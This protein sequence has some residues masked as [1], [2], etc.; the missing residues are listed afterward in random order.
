[1]VPSSETWAA[2]VAA[3]DDKFATLQGGAVLA[4]GVPD[5]EVP[6]PRE[7]GELVDGRLEFASPCDYCDFGDI[8]G[9]VPKETRW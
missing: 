5:E 8:C 9:F 6:K 3:Y 2:T 1:F 7:E 4:G